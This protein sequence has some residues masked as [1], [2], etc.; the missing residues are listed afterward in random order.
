MLCARAATDTRFGS[1]K[2]APIRLRVRGQH[3]YDMHGWN[4]A[5]RM[6]LA[7][8]LKA[9]RARR[10]NGPHGAYL[11][12]ALA[13]DSRY[14]WRMTR[15]L[16]LVMVVAMAS[17]RVIGKDNR[18]PWDL[19]EDRKHFVAV[20]R[21]HSIIMGRATWDSIG[22]PLPKRR[23]IVVSRQSKLQLPGAEVAHSLTEAIVLA[24]QTDD[25][26]RIV[27]GT[28]IYTEALALA[29]RIYLT[30]LDEAYEGD[31][32]CPALDDT[33]WHLSEERQGTGARYLTLDRAD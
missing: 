30:V 31:A 9:I 17:N 23:N 29:T 15:R 2:C 18:I 8:P 32:F 19:L 20:T 14:R 25:E 13:G 28:Q 4:I 16:P 7:N 27:G 11:N 22:K 6:L 10:A 24:R 12:V 3:S 21:G 33:Q 5:H 26:P 1:A